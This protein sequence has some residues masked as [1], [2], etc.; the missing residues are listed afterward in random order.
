MGQGRSAARWDVKEGLRGGVGRLRP[1]V[2]TRACQQG[3]A[4]GKV[5]LS[6]P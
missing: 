3:D 1:G 5:N 2:G 6:N 4:V